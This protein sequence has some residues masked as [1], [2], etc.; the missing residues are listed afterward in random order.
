MDNEILNKCSEAL[1]NLRTKAP[2]T[3]CITNI[4]TVNDCANAVLAIGA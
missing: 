2:L 4:V 1:E 3:Q